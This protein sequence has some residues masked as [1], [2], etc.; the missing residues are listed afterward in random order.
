MTI[1]IAEA[2]KRLPKKKTSPWPQSDIQ[3]QENMDGGGNRGCVG[4]CV[5]SKWLAKTWMALAMAMAFSTG[6]RNFQPSCS[7]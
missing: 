3:I 7:H 4:T 2:E 1:G 5:E 6:S